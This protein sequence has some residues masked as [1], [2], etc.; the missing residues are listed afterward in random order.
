MLI[1]M[2]ELLTFMETFSNFHRFCINYQGMYQNDE[3][4][5][6]MST[7]KSLV[8]EVYGQ[9]TSVQVSVIYFAHNSSDTWNKDWPPP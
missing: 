8:I 7:L 9:V 1:F 6:N 4:F 3:V 2:K 5:S